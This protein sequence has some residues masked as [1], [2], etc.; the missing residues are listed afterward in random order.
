MKN[1]YSSLEEAQDNI[2]PVTDGYVHKVFFKDPRE[3]ISS[4]KYLRR[5]TDI[6]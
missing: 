6:K 1:K 3:K 5:F 4:V 2:S